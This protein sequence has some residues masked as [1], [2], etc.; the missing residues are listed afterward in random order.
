[1]ENF[2][3]NGHTTKVPESAKE[4]KRPPKLASVVTGK[5]IRREKPLGRRFMETF[6]GRENSVWQYLLHEILI[7]A[8]K[9]TLTDFVSQG[10]EKM[11]YGESR[12]SSRRTGRPAGASNYT[13]YNRFSQPSERRQDRTM[14]RRARASHDF[15]EIVLRTRAEADAVIDSMMDYMQKY[16]QVTI[17][18]L[19]DLVGIQ[20]TFA[21]EK[22]GWRDL[23]GAGPTRIN[24]G[25]L[26]DLPRPE[27]LD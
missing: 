24:E 10:V 27:P 4:E 1:M 2:P 16:E 17:S 6:F 8:A 14:S 7:P 26:L 20:G 9:D 5:V 22:W 18:D 25:Y 15:Q 23:R 21:D 3:G 11:V 19:Y 12:S 13:P